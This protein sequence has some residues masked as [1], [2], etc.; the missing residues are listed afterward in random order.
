MTS[1]RRSFAAVT[2]CL[3][4]LVQV[5][6]AI[7]VSM[8]GA[9]ANRASSFMVWSAPKRILADTNSPRVGDMGVDSKGNLH[10]T[11]VNTTGSIFY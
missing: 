10:Y 6:I 3:L 5:F 11:W 2:L 1:S 8:V 4:M 9:D 7:P